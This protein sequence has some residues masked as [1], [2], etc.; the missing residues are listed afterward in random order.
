LRQKEK[1]ILIKGPFCF[2]FDNDKGQAPRYAI[3]FS[4]SHL[5]AQI[6]GETSVT[7]QTSLGDVDYEFFFNDAST[8]VTFQGVVSNQAAAG[9]TEEIR[10]VCIPQDILEELPLLI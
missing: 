8:A 4:L 1:F 9:E 6:K 2:V 3:S 10:K 5:K 7:L